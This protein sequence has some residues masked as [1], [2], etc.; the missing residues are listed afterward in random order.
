MMVCL[1]LFG[2]VIIN[3]ALLSKCG[4]KSVNIVRR[5]ER[6]NLN[7]DVIYILPARATVLVM[8]QAYR[9]CPNRGSAAT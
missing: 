9:V 1:R 2:P 6:P 8:F 4:I 3:V 5:P 7:S